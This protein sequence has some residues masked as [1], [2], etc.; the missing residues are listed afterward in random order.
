MKKYKVLPYCTKHQLHHGQKWP[1]CKIKDTNLEGGM[2]ET[3]TP[4][5][6]RVYF[7][8][9]RGPLRAKDIAWLYKMIKIQHYSGGW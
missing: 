3:D 7:K 1:S 4:S 9:L 2:F 5:G 8:V 6:A